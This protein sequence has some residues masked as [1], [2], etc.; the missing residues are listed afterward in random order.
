MLLTLLPTGFT[1]TVGS[2]AFI[3]SNA[4]ADI[5]SFGV[6]AQGVETAVV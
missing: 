3:S 4:A 2:I 5:T 6:G 1:C